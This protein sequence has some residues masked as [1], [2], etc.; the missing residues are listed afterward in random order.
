MPNISV[1]DALKNKNAFFLD[2]RSEKE[3][4]EDHIPGAI[5]VPILDNEERHLVGYT[6][7][8]K[9]KDEA[10]KIGY[11]IFDKK[12]SEFEKKIDEFKGKDVVFYCFRGGTRSSCFVDYFEKKG[13]KNIYKLDGGYKKYREEVRNEI[14]NVKLPKVVV[15]YGLTGAGKTRLIKRLNNSIDLEG[16]ASH[17]S[18]LF[19]AVGL[20]PRMQKMFETLLFEELGKKRDYLIL[21]GES[22]KIGNIIIPENIF[23][24]MNDS[25]KIDITCSL[26]TRA[27]RIVKEYFN[28]NERIK[29][30]KEVVPKLI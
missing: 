17:R 5:N 18:S 2:V 1:K 8:Q 22:R 27:K 26:D 20:K 13:K 10:Y 4:E 21:E 7:K 6:Y 16:L 19:G 11:E 15:L 28:D 3:F 25:I 30:V 9:S 24:S 12:I 14:K 29:Q 23:K